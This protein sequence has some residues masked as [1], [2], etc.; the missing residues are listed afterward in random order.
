MCGI[1]GYY[2]K[3]NAAPFLLDGLKKLEYRGYDSAG[4]AL[5]RGGKINLYRCRGRVRELGSARREKGQLGIGHTRWATHGAP[6]EANAHPHVYGKFAIVHNGIIENQFEL[7]GELLARGDTFSSET[8][9]EVIAHLL[10]YYYEGDLLA[11]MQKTAGRLKGSYAVAAMCEEIPDALVCARSKS[12]LVVGEGN[13]GVYVASDLSAIAARGVAL[14]A[15]GDGEFALLNG[16]GVTV[17]DRDLTVIP[18]EPLEYD[19]EA[20]APDKR[21]YRHYMRKEMAEI[22][23]VIGKSCIDFARDPA[24]EELTRVLGR[25]QRIHIVACGTAYHSGLC[26]KFAIESLCRI[27]VE[28]CV[29]SE[30]RYRNPIVP[31]DT[32][33][34][35]VTQSGETADTLAAAE[36]AKQAGAYLVAVTNVPYSSITRIA[37]TVLFTGAGREIAVAATK[38][39]NAQLELLYCIAS[40]LAESKGGQ[41]YFAELHRL[42]ETV[43]AAEKSCE[44][45][46]GWIPYFLGARSVFFLGRGADYAAALEGSL[47]LKEITYLPSEG[48]AAGELK[49]GTLALVDEGTPVVA[50]LT[51]PALAEKT[52]NAVH[53]VYARGANVFLITSLPEYVSRKEVSSAVLLP[54]CRA[55]FSPVLSVLPLQALAYYLSIARGNNPDKPRNLAKSVTVE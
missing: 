4:I 36:L 34:L 15:L 33:A 10:A 25:T 43:A 24:Y 13:G 31:P 26:A 42:I 28:V 27:P 40:A 29:A 55:E 47:K 7:K 46:R 19:P 9:S 17:Y 16:K 21:G 44:E 38:S 30:Y 48:Y 39:F 45:V 23:A 32:L 11:A 6:S 3:E 20:E 35:A 41:S 18:K 54:A 8:D 50:L 14:Y 52:M 53:E 37:D 49:H 12:P 2:G 22:P 5:L 51:D 1:V